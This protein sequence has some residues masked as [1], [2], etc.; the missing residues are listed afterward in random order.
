MKEVSI[1]CLLTEM[2]RSQKE[3]FQMVTKTREILDLDIG[4]II[5]WLGF[6]CVFIFCFYNICVGSGDVIGMPHRWRE[7]TW[8]LGS[9]R[10]IRLRG[11]KKTSITGSAK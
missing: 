8:S 6:T 2:N 5:Y 7:W 4:P 1:P 10:S 9:G 11:D 3:K